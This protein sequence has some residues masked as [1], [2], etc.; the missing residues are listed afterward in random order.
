M[1]CHGLFKK[2]FGVR[3]Q[4]SFA[5]IWSMRAFVVFLNLMPLY[6][7]NFELND[8]MDNQLERSLNKV[9]FNVL[10]AMTLVS[11]GVASFTRPLVIP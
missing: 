4:M 9:L 5:F 11:Y 2:V 7:I 3:G 10:A 1:T 8:W 6:L